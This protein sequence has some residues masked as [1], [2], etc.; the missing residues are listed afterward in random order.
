MAFGGIL[1]QCVM[2]YRN[3]AYAGLFFCGDDNRR[4]GILYGGAIFACRHC[5][6][7][8]YE[9]QHEQPYDRALR[10]TQNIRERLGA[11]GNWHVKAQEAESRCWPNWVY[12]L[13]LAN[14]CAQ[15][16]GATFS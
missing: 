6:R 1:I 7:L 15:T 8:A 14:S 5:R 9:S 16:P 10:R 12:R 13:A 2:P 3:S 4:V 11:S